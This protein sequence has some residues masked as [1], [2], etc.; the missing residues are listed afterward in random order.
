[1]SDTV[2]HE[3]LILMNATELSVEL[4]PLPQMGEC[5]LIFELD[6]EDYLFI[7]YIDK[8]SRIQLHAAT[9][10]SPRTEDADFIKMREEIKRALP[11][12]RLIASSATAADVM[13]MRADDATNANNMVGIK[14]L[15]DA[16]RY[17][18][19]VLYFNRCELAFK[20]KLREGK[21]EPVWRL[22]DEIGIHHLAIDADNG[23]DI[24]LTT[25]MSLFNLIW[26]LE[27]FLGLCSG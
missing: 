20:F 9:Y 7:Y 27:R 16:D 12:F 18:H 23:K 6:D 1:M 10:P 4:P 26:E 17:L 25:K 3:M 22:D 15:L 19:I 11:Y 5:G 24:E 8:C 21:E 2:K 14:G 13:K